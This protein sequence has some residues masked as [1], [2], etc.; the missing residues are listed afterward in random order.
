[1][2]CGGSNSARALLSTGVAARLRGAATSK[3]RGI[4]MLKQWAIGLVGAVALIG[5]V[6]AA[7]IPVDAGPPVYQGAAPRYAP[8]PLA[9]LSPYAP[10][11]VVYGY[12]PPPVVYYD[13]VP[14]VVVYPG[15]YGYGYGSGYGPRYYGY[16]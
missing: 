7:D 10:P 16:R 5:P 6:A 3:E 11:R 12:A 2:P 8:P 14:P 13:D 4:P 9:R 15:R 1:M